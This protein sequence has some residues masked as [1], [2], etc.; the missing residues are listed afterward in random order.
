MRPGLQCQFAL[1]ASNSDGLT[2]YLT[3]FPSWMPR[4]F[5]GGG[6]EAFAIG[7]DDGFF[8]PMAEAGDGFAADA[9]DFRDGPVNDSSQP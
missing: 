6:D 9:D 8:R 2:R 1:Q 7:L 4:G 5:L 3:K